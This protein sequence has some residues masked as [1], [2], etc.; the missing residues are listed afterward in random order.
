MLPPPRPI[1]TAPAIDPTLP[2]YERGS[3]HIPVRSIEKTPTPSSLPATLP[4][5]SRPDSKALSERSDS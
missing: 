1:I 4:V 2:L 5:E 3:S